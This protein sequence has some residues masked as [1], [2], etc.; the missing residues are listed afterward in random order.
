MEPFILKAIL[1][2]L[3]LLIVAVA[4]LAAYSLRNP[5]PYFSW[6]L[7]H[8]A[9]GVLGILAVLFL[10]VNNKLDAAASAI[11]SSIVAYSLGAARSGQSATRP[12]QPAAGNPPAGQE[13]A[14]GH[15]GCKAMSIES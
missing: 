8:F 3:G 5:Q 11:L 14:S 1:A 12:G 7:L 10:A 2:A 4:L 9:I 13:D 15:G 6:F